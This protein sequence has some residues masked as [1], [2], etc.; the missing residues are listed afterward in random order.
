M[1]AQLFAEIEATCGVNFTVETAACLDLI[2]Q[3]D[4]E[5]GFALCAAVSAELTVLQAVL[6]LRLAAVWTWMR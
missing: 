5:V 1:H 4:T 3:M 2:N 6:H